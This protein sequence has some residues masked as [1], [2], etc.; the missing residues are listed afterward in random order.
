MPIMGSYLEVC[1]G[2]GAT[3][4]KEQATLKFFGPKS[5]TAKRDLDIFAFVTGLILNL[6]CSSPKTDINPN[7]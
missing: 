4:D 6:W 1:A 5:E 3:Q 7:T 2:R